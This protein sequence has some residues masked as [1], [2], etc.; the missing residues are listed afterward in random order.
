M[1]TDHITKER[2][3]ILEKENEAFKT[4]LL[5]FIGY[6]DEWLLTKPGLK[7]NYKKEYLMEHIQYQRELIRELYNKL[8]DK[9]QDELRIKVESCIWPIMHNED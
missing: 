9:V 6:E 4:L 1:T 7:K 2:L 8:D 5:E 3:K